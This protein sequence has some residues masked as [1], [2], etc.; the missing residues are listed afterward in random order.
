[1]IPIK[2]GQQRSFLSLTLQ[3]SF[4]ILLT[5]GFSVPP[6]RYRRR[7]PLFAAAPR[8]ID[9]NDDP[10]TGTID[11]IRNP[12]DHSIL[13]DHEGV[14][15]TVDRMLATK[16]LR[17][18]LMTRP[19]PGGRPLTY[20]SGDS[21]TRNLND[22]FG[23]N[24]WNLQILRSDQ[25]V[26]TEVENPRGGKQWHVLY[27]THVRIT[28]LPSGCFREDI[29]CGDVMDRSVVVASQ[30]AVKASVTDAMKRAARHFGDKLGNSLYDSEFNI[31]NAPGTLAEA[32]D[33][34]D[35]E[36]AQ[37]KFGR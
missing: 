13:S 21:V 24:Q 31:Q 32:L 12:V 10:S 1:M 23:F 18:D 14:P 17:S 3:W 25:I 35:E 6:F 20:L 19:G 34:Y 11:Y 33:M 4:C 5:R 29:G 7:T 8:R 27:S 15:I 26:C 9:V 37:A 28:H 2:K 36:R 30:N 22:I 16:P